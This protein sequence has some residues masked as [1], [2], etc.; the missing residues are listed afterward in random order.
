ML[1][2]PFDMRADLA[3]PVPEHGFDRVVP[4]ERVRSQIPV[5]YDVVR[6]AGDEAESLVAGADR[7]FGDPLLGHVHD[8][9]HRRYDF[10]G[11]IANRRRAHANEALGSVASPDLDLL[12][13]HRLVA[14]NGPRQRP[15]ERSERSSIRGEPDELTISAQVRRGLER[16][17]EDLSHLGVDRDEAAGGNF[18]NDE[19]DGHLLLNGVG[20]RPF[21]NQTKLQI[22]NAALG[23][24]S[25]NFRYH[26][27]A[28]HPKQVH[29]AL[30]PRSR[31]RVEGA[32]GT[33]D[34]SARCYEWNSGI[35][36]DG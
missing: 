1:V 16:G 6:C 27:G 29:V 13:T 33:D 12:A 32:E 28:Q 36:P 31:T 22:L 35:G 5:P 4:D 20:E 18:S 2:P 17:S 21:R 3:L 25:L 30:R 24:A 11:G 10:A 19:P 15:V 26:R 14:Q 23:N 8:D 9:S 7:P 34:L